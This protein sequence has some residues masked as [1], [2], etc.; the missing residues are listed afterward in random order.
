[1]IFNLRKNKTVLIVDDEQGVKDTAS[2]I[3]ESWGFR[4]LTEESG[5]KA[6]EIAKKNKPDLIILDLNIP[7]IDG[8]NVCRILKKDP[9]THKIPIIL[10]T[11]MGK[12]PDIDKGFKCG[13]DDY[14]IKPLDWDRLKMKV[15]D[16]LGIDL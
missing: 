16:L 11:G 9:S 10:L 2:L 7:D 12:S 14:L 13:A 1:M 4:I 3:F 6:V 15:S 8:F 5:F